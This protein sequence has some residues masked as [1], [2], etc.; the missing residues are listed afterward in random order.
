MDEILFPIESKILHNNGWLEVSL[1]M[2]KPSIEER[3]AGLLASYRKKA[4]SS[5]ISDYRVN[6]LIELI[7]S[8]NDFKKVFITKLPVCTE[9]LKIESEFFNEDSVYAII[10]EQCPTTEFIDLKPQGL[11]WIDGH[12]VF[13]NSVELMSSRL[14]Q[15]IQ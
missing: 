13:K 7:D 1:E 15:R 10:R 5:I 3:K 14:S 12:H 8:L 9:L 2:D 6:S 4:K 11:I